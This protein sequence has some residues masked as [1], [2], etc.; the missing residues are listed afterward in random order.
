MFTYAVRRYANGYYEDHFEYLLHEEHYSPA[1]FENMLFDCVVI[2]MES[3]SRSA[4]MRAQLNDSEL[5]PWQRNLSLG[6]SGCYCQCDRETIN[7][8]CQGYGFKKLEVVATVTLKTHVSLD[9]P[10][11]VDYES[12]RGFALGHDGELCDGPEDPKY[13]QTRRLALRVQE[14]FGARTRP[15]VEAVCEEDDSEDA[16]L[17]F[18][19]L[20]DDIFFDDEI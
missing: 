17:D 10:E 12:D 16:L 15:V 3:G 2:A 13:A 11:D 7:L 9:C 6:A 14:K 19:N 20:A 8:M 5:E 1:E 4:E 18:P